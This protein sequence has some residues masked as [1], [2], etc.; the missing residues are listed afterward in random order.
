MAAS[1]E[2]LI[3]QKMAA[4][5]DDLPKMKRLAGVWKTK[6]S[7]ICTGAAT[8]IDRLHRNLGDTDLCARVAAKM[9]EILRNHED[10]LRA[11]ERIAIHDDMPDKLFST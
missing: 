9:L 8:S 6:F 3:E 10:V 7:N 1:S 2:G 4:C 5:E 11:Y